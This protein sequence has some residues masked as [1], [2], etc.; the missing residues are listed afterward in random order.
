MIVNFPKASYKL[1]NIEK[2][3]TY[4]EYKLYVYSGQNVHTNML[5]FNNLVEGLK[6]QLAA[7]CAENGI[8]YRLFLN[9]ELTHKIIVKTILMWTSFELPNIKYKVK[10]VLPRK[11]KQYTIMINENGYKRLSMHVEIKFSI[12]IKEE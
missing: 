1:L 3:N 5:K 11:K 10:I 8:F 12:L 6:I 9:R 4:V 7:A 2:S